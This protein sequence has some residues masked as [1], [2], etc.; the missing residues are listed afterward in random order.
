MLLKIVAKNDW[1]TKLIKAYRKRL[2]F[3]LSYL[4]HK[5]LYSVK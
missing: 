5:L 4:N 3:S 1:I 2:V